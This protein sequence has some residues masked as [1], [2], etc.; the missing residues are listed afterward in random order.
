[1]KLEKF[2]KKLGY[3][4]HDVLLLELALSHR[5]AD[6]N[7]N[8]RFEFL[9]D[10]ILNFVIAEKLFQIF[11][12]ATEG[13][14]SR[15]RAALV[16]KRTLANLA[17]E[18]EVSHYLRLGLAE[19]KNGGAKRE[20]IL[21]DTLEAIIGAIYLDGGVEKCQE[22]ILQWYAPHL[23][24]MLTFPVE[25]DAKTQLQ[26]YFQARQLSLPQYR[27]TSIDGKSHAQVFYV[28][29]FVEGFDYVTK[30]SAASRREAE[31]MAAKRYLDCL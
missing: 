9:G 7:H 11:P 26:E 17:K 25:K 8:E 23:Q 22:K 6:T 3:Q 10:S 2:Y 12:G 27:V 4:F 15:F 14:L 5:S 28:E 13:E 19:I 31:Q 18:L 30:G 24:E 21:A 29:C 1:M 20:S 16:N